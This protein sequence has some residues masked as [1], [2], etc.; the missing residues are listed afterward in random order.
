MTKIFHLLVAAALVTSS[1]A[2]AARARIDAAN[3]PCVHSWQ[4][5][6]QAI[7]HRPGSPRNAPYVREAYDI[8]RGQPYLDFY[9]GMD[10][11][12]EILPDGALAR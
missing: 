4:R 11:C 10:T 8:H 5:D 12:S 6:S 3:F 9:P 7:E 1:S 2:I